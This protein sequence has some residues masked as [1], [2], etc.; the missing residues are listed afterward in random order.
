MVCLPPTPLSYAGYS[1]TVSG[2][3]LTDGNDQSSVPLKLREAEL[4][5]L[6]NSQCR[7]AFDAA[8][9][10]GGSFIQPSMLCAT[11]P[12]KGSCSG[13]SGGIKFI[14]SM[15]ACNSTSYI[16]RPTHNYY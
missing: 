5:V 8:F 4:T 15:H 9:A 13:D 2:W 6:S 3:G 16:P 10:G 11:A 1:A 14:I 7:Q 12:G